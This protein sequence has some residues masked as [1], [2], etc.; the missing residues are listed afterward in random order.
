MAGS[1][2]KVDAIRITYPKAPN[3]DLPT[4]DKNRQRQ[5]FQRIPGIEKRV[6][7]LEIF[8]RDAFEPDQRLQAIPHVP[9]NTCYRNA[10][11]AA[12]FNVAPFVNYINTVS[13]GVYG[14]EQ[15]L[16]KD[17]LQQPEKFIIFKYLADLHQEFR[18]GGTSLRDHATRFWD[19]LR[20]VPGAYPKNTEESNDTWE[21]RLLHGMKID[22]GLNSAE[23]SLEL[24]M[25]LMTRLATVE[26]PDL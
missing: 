16:S 20:K 21:E 22:R 3:H 18:H 12:L 23:D 17:A 26:Q 24:Y 7:P 15:A 8:N 9:A 5:A 11:L 2:K 19:Y 6:V 1:K 14:S 25:Y 13:N 10:M 4:P